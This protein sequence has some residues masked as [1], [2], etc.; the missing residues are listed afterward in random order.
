[1]KKSSD[2]KHKAISICGQSSMIAE[3]VR[4]SNHYPIK[5][6]YHAN[7]PITELLT[8]SLS[9][10]NHGLQLDLTRCTPRLTP[11]TTHTACSSDANF[12]TPA[13][14]CTVTTPH[15]Q[16]S[17]LSIS[18]ADGARTSNHWYLNCGSYRWP[19]SA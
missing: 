7:P 12:I 15:G 4:V 2:L 14:S 6:L 11:A 1:M 19:D 17:P 8:I 9:N 16:H 10:Y 5:Y 3:S 13:A 18:F